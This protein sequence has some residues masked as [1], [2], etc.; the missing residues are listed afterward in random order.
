MDTRYLMYHY[1]GK[2]MKEKIALAECIE[3]VMKRDPVPSVANAPMPKSAI[4]NI[5]E[6][7]DLMV[8]EPTV[9]YGKKHD[10]E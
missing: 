3:A 2:P 4:Y 8:A 10:T 6:M 1:S 7:P 9:G 5:P